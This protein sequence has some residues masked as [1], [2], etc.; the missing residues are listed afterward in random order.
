MIL[1]HSDPHWTA[2]LFLFHVAPPRRP[3]YG[4]RRPPAT[5]RRA[6]PRVPLGA[7]GIQTSLPASLPVSSPGGADRHTATEAVMIG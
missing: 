4:L 7:L 2:H 5:G 1:A 6:L 3:D